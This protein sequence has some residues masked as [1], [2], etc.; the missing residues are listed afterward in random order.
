MNGNVEVLPSSVDVMG[1]RTLAEWA[2]A[3]PRLADADYKLFLAEIRLRNAKR[4]RLELLSKVLKER[5]DSLPR[6]VAETMLARLINQAAGQDII[7]LPLTKETRTFWFG[8]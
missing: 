7:P 1:E 8:D 4:R 6:P 2:A 5:W 3:D